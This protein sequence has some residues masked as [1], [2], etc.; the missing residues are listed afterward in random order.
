MTQF[1]LCLPERFIYNFNN[2]N[3]ALVSIML[4]KVKKVKLGE[5]IKTTTMPQGW[6]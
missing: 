5:T 4:W 2:V 3:E 6:P 1:P